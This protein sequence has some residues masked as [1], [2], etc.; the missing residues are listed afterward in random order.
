MINTPN[1]NEEN[2]QDQKIADFL[3]A[4]EWLARLTE[5]KGQYFHNGFSQYY[6]QSPEDK[7]SIEFLLGVDFPGGRGNRKGFTRLKE[8]AR[9]RFILRSLQ[10][11]QKQDGSKLWQASGTLHGI[12][13]SFRVAPLGR[14][15]RGGRQVNSELEQLLFE[16]YEIDNDPPTSQDHLYSIALEILEK[17]GIRPSENTMK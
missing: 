10:L 17:N 9:N 7:K 14:L 1:P 13:E 8:A 3:D 4:M 5:P 15:R 16:I 6:K 12:M 2:L 11:L